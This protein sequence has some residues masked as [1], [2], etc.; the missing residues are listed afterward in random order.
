MPGPEIQSVWPSPHGIT[1]LSDSEKLYRSPGLTDV[2]EFWGQDQ[3]QLGSS[4][5]LKRFNDELHREWAIETGLIENLYDI[6][7]GTTL[8]LIEQGFSAANLPHGSTNKPEEYVLQLLKDQQ[9]ALEGLF[10]FVK[11][12]RPLSTSYVNDLH[13][14]MTRSQSEV[15]AQM[16]DGAMTK[17]PMLHGKYKEHPNSPQRGGVVFEYCPPERTADQMDRLIELH[18]VHTSEGVSPEVEAA[19]LH[20]RFTQIHPYQDGNGRV[21]RAL[22][23]LV[24]IRAGL[25]PLVVS[26]DDKASYLDFLKA[27]DAGDLLPLIR[28]ITRL[29][30]VRY[31]KAKRALIKSTTRPNSVKEALAQYGEASDLDPKK[32]DASSRQLAE[33]ARDA[34]ASSLRHLYRQFTPDE[35]SGAGFPPAN[36]GVEVNEV[37]D[38]VARERLKAL[39]GNEYEDGLTQPLWLCSMVLRPSG[40][41]LPIGIVSPLVILLTGTKWPYLA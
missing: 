14:A 34:I 2:L 22:A 10:H 26:V 32:A 18:L 35:F 11:Q 30:Q 8:I 1:D 5:A 25:F 9:D 24:L 33:R 29:Q 15:D 39:A 6:E 19:W 27:A 40:E 38:T 37:S 20:H 13:H 7:R 41:V 31:R 16:P 28:M 23:S 3:K 36:G 17:V 12:G 4:E 21:A